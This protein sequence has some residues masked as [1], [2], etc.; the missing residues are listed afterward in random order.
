LCLVRVFV[1]FVCLMVLRTDVLSCEVLGCDVLGPS[2]V[3]YV[4]SIVLVLCD[5]TSCP[6]LACVRLP[7]CGFTGLWYFRCEVW[8]HAI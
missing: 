8:F 3:R 5:V 2:S 4:V 1:L 7:Y 6:V